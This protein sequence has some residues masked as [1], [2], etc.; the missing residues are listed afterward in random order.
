MEHI[1]FATLI[2]IA[3]FASLGHCVGMCGGIVL[4]LSTIYTPKHQGH[5]SSF[6]A[7]F[8]SQILIQALY[9]SGKITSYCML[10]FVAGSLGDIATPNEHVKYSILL[11]VGVLLVVY[12]IVVGQFFRIKTLSFE[13]PFTRR[14]IIIMQSILAKNTKWQI[15]VLGLCNGFLPCGIVYYFLLSACV[16][17]SGLNGAL[18][19]A[20]FGI[21]IMPSL[22]LLAFISSSIQHKR[23]LFLRLSGVGMVGFGFYEIYK[24]FKVLIV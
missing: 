21:A 11:G 13:L 1:E 4:A 14:L 20:V 23:I 9:H 18:V 24:A 16:A 17:G 12:G 2:G 6:S 10:G 7:P 3:F 19:M 5:S 22:L 15:Y 8:S